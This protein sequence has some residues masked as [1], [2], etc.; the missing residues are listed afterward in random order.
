MIFKNFFNL[1]DSADKT[2]NVIGCL[3]KS[4][5]VVA[6]TGH[7]QEVLNNH[8]D[9][10]SLLSLSE[11]LLE[12]GLKT[13]AVKGTISD[14]S[15]VDYPGIAVLNGGGYVVLESISDNQFT[16]NIPGKGTTVMT[17][18]AFDN[19]W[20]GIILRVIASKITREENYH[21]HFRQ[22]ILSKTRRYFVFPGLILF[23]LVHFILEAFSY[24]EF[25]N[26]ILP[27]ALLK[28]IGL[29]ICATMFA[30]S[31]GNKRI[32]ERVCLESKRTNCRRVMESPAGKLLGIPMADLGLLYFA[33]GFLTLFA[34][35]SSLQMEFSLC[36][37][38]I[39][40]IFALP[41]TFFAII[42][43]AFVVRS[44]CWL[45][46]TVQVIFW[47][48][49]VAVYSFVNKVPV[50]AKWPLMLP[51]IFGFG[52]TVIV[53]LALRPIL[54]KYLLHNRKDAELNRINSS[55]DYI[56]LK[57]SR[58]K[59]GSVGCLPVEV[60]IGSPDSSI[61]LTQVVN[62]LCRHC[63]QTFKEMVQ[64]VKLGNGNIKG[65]VRFLIAGSDNKMTENEKK[66]DYDVALQIIAMTVA[67]RLDDAHDALSSWFSSNHDINRRFF[68]KW[69]KK[70]PDC[71]D[72][73]LKKASDLLKL[74]A[75]WAIDSNIHSTPTI[76][77]NDL[78][79]SS[80]ISFKSLK[81][82]L[83]RHISD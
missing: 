77:L 1:S 70:Y 4:I 13:E 54:K 74:H 42:Y 38:G 43:Q 62:P 33:G 69:K 5:G 49:F 44:W 23:F 29:V 27:L 11:T 81:Y 37:L 75:K 16:V 17:E 76:F 50:N 26:K 56:A 45:C 3:L 53:W 46:L 32:L 20:S 60:T 73:E 57:L 6:T 22:Q 8:P 82:Y 36:I 66:M 28:I 30:G 31:N 61:S 79:L 64:L 72:I 48:E 18:A 47:C 41:Y 21:L 25:L 55:P 19:A 40:N 68:K 15:E 58:L 35:N 51:L 34:S 83:I 12:F 52:L 80:D 78:K 63:S 67:E 10:P 39:I 9:Y 59:N 14:L 71:S 7:I 24:P 65:H 2:V